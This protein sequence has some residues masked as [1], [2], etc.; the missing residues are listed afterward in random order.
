V[1]GLTPAQ[2]IEHYPPLTDEDVRAA[3]A[4]AAELSRT[5]E[6]GTK[7]EAPSTQEKRAALERLRGLLKFEGGPPTDEEV[8]DMITDYLVEKYS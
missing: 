3:V 4:Y 2:I 7:A 5:K 6:R 8:K 1:E